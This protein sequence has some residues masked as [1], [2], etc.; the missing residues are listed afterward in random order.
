[1]N[2]KNILAITLLMGINL[3]SYAQSD[4]RHIKRD[5]VIVFPKPS[6]PRGDS[7]KMLPKENTPI[8]DLNKGLPGNYNNRSTK[9]PLN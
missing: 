2:T 6:K 5:S 8:R 1:M 9:Q 4:D 7:I 3:T